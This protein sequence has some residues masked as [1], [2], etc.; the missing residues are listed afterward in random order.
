MNSTVIVNSNATLQ[1][2]LVTDLSAHI[3]WGIGHINDTSELIN[4]KFNNN[5]TIIQVCLCSLQSI[6]MLVAV[7]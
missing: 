4:G 3:M 5:V 1:C 7:Q 6:F 2:P